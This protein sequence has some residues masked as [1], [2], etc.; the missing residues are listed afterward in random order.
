[1]SNTNLTHDIVKKEAVR[2]LRNNTVFINSV[3]PQYDDSFSTM[4]AKGGES[5]RIQTPQEFSVREGLNI[6]QQDVEQKAVTLNVTNVFGVDI[7]YSDAEL[8]QD[9]V[10]GFNQN[11]V[12][13]AMATLA[14]YADNWA[15]SQVY[16]EIAQT[17]TLPV[18]NLDRADVLNA[19]IKLDNG[20]APRDG[21]RYFLAN[22]QG[23]GD[24]VND[25]AA[26]FHAAENLSQQYKDGIVSVPSFGFNFG[27]SQNMPTHTCGSYD[28]NYDVAAVPSSGATTLDVD[29]GTGIIK[30]GDIFTI[31]TVY[32]VN[33]ITKA[34][35]GKL[36]QF[37][38]QADSAGGDVDL[39]IL[40][41]I[42]YEGPYQNVDSAPAA[43]DDLVFVGT[44]D[45]AYPQA[46]AY[47]SDAF[48]I[49]FCDLELP[50]GAASASRMVEDGCSMRMTTFWDGKTSVSWMRFDLMLGVKTIIDRHACRVYS[51]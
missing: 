16:K 11:K 51:F 26:L 15:M 17:V 49:G 13:P 19:G 30:A 9:N 22:P 6:D 38:V 41:A 43:N 18:T 47:H 44:A 10:D 25:S 28:A 32:E 24:I 7:K 4:G 20:T 5:I 29:T 1:M 48:A 12:K 39:E 14:G 2:V 42:I 35:T 46:L 50:A 40:P 23:H 21:D 27:M 37:T 34:S 36:K 3:K 45:A 8:T 31:A 33:P